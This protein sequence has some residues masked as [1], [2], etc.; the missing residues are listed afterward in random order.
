MQGTEC[1]DICVSNP[2]SHSGAVAWDSNLLGDALAD[3]GRVHFVFLNRDSKD[4]TT[5]F[6]GL[7]RYNGD[8]FGIQQQ[9]K[10][11]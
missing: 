11:G 5:P 2:A 9:C 8:T 6:G 4:S 10:F 7:D 3:V 1:Q